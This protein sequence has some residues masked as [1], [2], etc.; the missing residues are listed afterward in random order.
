[1][2]AR[3]DTECGTFDVE[4]DEDAAPVTGSYF[5]T[6]IECKAFDGT[7]FFRIVG[8]DNASFR[9]ASPIEVIQGGL[10]ETDA[11]PVPPVAHE[12]TAMTGLSHLK[13]TLSA[14][15]FAP[16]QT[17]GSFFICMRDEPALDHGGERHPDGQGFA[18]FGRVIA[19]FD[20][21]EAIFA[22][23]EAA[24]Y[25]EAPVALHNCRMLNG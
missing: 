12:S 15:R 5:A 7:G 3:F 9:A 6:L 4:I 21:V 10:R 8:P 17:Y 16:G 23:S 14:A 2:K 13:W 18:A 22:R 20:T 24:E 11:Q 19:G 25:L 1:M